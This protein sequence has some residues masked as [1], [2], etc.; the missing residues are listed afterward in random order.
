MAYRADAS[1]QI[2]TGR[3]DAGRH[4]HRAPACVGAATAGASGCADHDRHDHVAHR[5][6]ASEFSQAPAGFDARIA[7]QNAEGGVDGHKIEA[8][9][10]DDQ[11]SPSTEIV[12]AVQDAFSKGAIGIVSDSPLF[13]LAA[14]YPTKQGVPVTGGFFDGPE[15]G[16]QPFTN[17]FAADVGSLEPRRTR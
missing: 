11:T 2:G 1:G 7:L 14:K 16:T 10:L 9:V 15:W 5:R 6:G 8:I 17:M 4:C 3:P 12:T 13:F